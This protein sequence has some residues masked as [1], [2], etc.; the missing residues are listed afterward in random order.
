MPGTFGSLVGVLL[1]IN[2]KK[3]FTILQY[4]IIIIIII[5]LLA[6]LAID[7]YQKKMEKKIVQ[8]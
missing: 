5:Q 6:V 7:I 2:F 1:G 4:I 8:K 3:P